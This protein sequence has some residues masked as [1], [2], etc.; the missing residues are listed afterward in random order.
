[1][2]VK[3]GTKVNQT[4]RESCWPVQVCVGSLEFEV[5]PPVFSVLFD[6]SLPI[7]RAPAISSFAGPAAKVPNWATTVRGPL[8]V[9]A[10]GFVDPVNAPPQPLNTYPEPATARTDTVVP[11]AK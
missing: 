6:G 11:G 9:T 5:A 1:M 7:A 3:F 4:V 2:P 10:A 8:M